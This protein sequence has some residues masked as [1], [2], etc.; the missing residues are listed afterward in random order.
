MS[1]RDGKTAKRSKLN[2]RKG[3]R[4]PNCGKATLSKSNCKCRVCRRSQNN[5]MCMTCHWSNF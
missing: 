2:F 5:L 1:N 3:Q 4:C